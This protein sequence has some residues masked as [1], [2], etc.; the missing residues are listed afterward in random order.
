MSDPVPKPSGRATLRLGNRERV[1]LQTAVILVIIGLLAI[2]LRPLFVR[3]VEVRD[4]QTCQTNVRKMAQALGIYAQEWDD[5]FP[6]ADVWLDAVRGRMAAVDPDRY[7]KC[8]K[9]HSSAPSSYLYNETMAGLSLSVRRDDPES[10][11]RRRQLR[12]LDRAALVIEKHGSAENAHAPLPDWDA[13][14]ASMTLPHNMP[15]A[16]GSII[17]G[18]GRAW[19]RS[20]E[21]L[22]SSAGRR[23]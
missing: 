4:F 15:E 19:F 9:D 13:V 3:L 10:T 2:A 1:R 18:N 17:F 23:F 22:Q 16:T 12:R 21:A 14:A 6:L 5:T 20:R 11:A 7:L 8:P